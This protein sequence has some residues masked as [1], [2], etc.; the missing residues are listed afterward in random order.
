V[1]EALPENTEF[2]SA[3]SGVN[4]LKYVIEVNGVKTQVQADPETPLIYVL[5]NDLAVKSVRYGCGEEQCGACRVIIDDEIG[6]ACTL[7]VADVGDRSIRTVEG[8]SSGGELHALQKAFL[9]ENAAQCAYCSSGVLMT[10]QH[11]LEH[12]PSPT[13]AEIQQALAGN[14]CRCGAHNRIIHAVMNAAKQVAK[15]TAGEITGG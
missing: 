10:A 11:L 14:L 13:R 7:P 6:F 15:S 1:L 12:N 3:R 9:K 2:I 8:L 5:R 4:P